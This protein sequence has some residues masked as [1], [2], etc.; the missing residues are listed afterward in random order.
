MSNGHAYIMYPFEGEMAHL[1]HRASSEDRD[2]VGLGC[3]LHGSMLI[4][5]YYQSQILIDLMRPC[6]RT[7]GDCVS[8]VEGPDLPLDWQGICIHGQF[9]EC[10]DIP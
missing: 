5:E 1:A 6:A 2:N 10:N 3:L 8:V 7:S 9:A 4:G